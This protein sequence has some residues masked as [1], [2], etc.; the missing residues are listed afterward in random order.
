MSGLLVYVR[1]VTGDV[2]AVELP[3]SAAVGDVIEEFARATDRAPSSIRLGS[4]SAELDPATTLADAGIG[5]EATLS[6]L[7][8]ALEWHH[9]HIPR[10][11]RRAPGP[12]PSVDRARPD[13]GP[14]RLRC[15]RQGARSPGGAAAKVPTELLLE[16]P[17]TEHGGEVLTATSTRNHQLFAALNAQFRP[18]VPFRGPL[19]N[20]DEYHLAM[21]FG[22]TAGA[23]H[24]GLKQ[25]SAELLLYIDAGVPYC[26][27]N[28]ENADV[29]DPADTLYVKVPDDA[30]FR[31]LVDGDL[32]ISYEACSG[33]ARQRTLAVPQAINDVFAQAVAAL[34]PGTAIF[35]YV[36]TWARPEEAKWTVTQ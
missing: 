16:G 26:R 25:D 8:S 18:G 36:F 20:A 19:F 21:G 4:G 29:G 23:P 2:V 27:V 30:P 33:G 6:E 11:S 22:L 31:L 10:G 17:G 32:R 5:A 9:D 7:S 24:D 1:P 3:P 34:P 15:R 12:S 13:R 35:P 28:G 14:G